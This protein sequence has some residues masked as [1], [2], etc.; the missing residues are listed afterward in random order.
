MTSA[1]TKMRLIFM[2]IKMHMKT[3]KIKLSGARTEMR[4]ICWKAL[5]KFDTSVV[6]RVTSPADENL[7]MLEKEKVWILRNMALRRL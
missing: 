5:C 7:S 1:T 2:L 4:R 3:L 6:M